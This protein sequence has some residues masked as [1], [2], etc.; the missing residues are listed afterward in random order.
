MTLSLSICGFLIFS[1]AL[2][3]GMIPLWVKS[4]NENLLKLFIS[5]GAGLLLSMAFLHMIPEAFNLIPETFG[6]W[7]LVGFCLLLFLERF[8]MVHA[9]EEHGCHY[10]TIGIAA[11]MGLTIHG[12]IEGFALASSQLVTN[13]GFLV[14]IAILSHKAPAGIALTSILKMSGK[15]PVQIL[16][17]VLGVALSGPIGIFLAYWLLKTQQYSNAAGILLSISAGTFLYIGACDL[18]PE[19]HRTD[20]EKIKRLLS[21]CLGIFVSVLSGHLLH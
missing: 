18:L 1:A 6:I 13:L 5:F 14:L 21:F 12:L 8:I 2:I 11:F 3:G 16:G 15:K 9:C 10:H 4:Q 7:L 17:F 19:I 20:G